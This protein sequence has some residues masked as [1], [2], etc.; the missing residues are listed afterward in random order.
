MLLSALKDDFSLNAEGGTMALS[1]LADDWS[2]NALHDTERSEGTL[3]ISTFFL[4][5][6]AGNFMVDSAGNFM[7][8]LDSEYVYP[9]KLHALADD[10]NLNA[11]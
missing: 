1:A 10:F 6:S 11:S 4:V 5:D 9:Q 3:V 8:A 7:V 2:L